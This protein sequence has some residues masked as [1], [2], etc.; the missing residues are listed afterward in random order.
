VL[1]DASGRLNLND[2]KLIIEAAIQGL[3]IAFVPALCADDALTDGRLIEL[4]NDWSTPF[5]GLCLYYASNR[6]IP[7]ALKAFIDIVRA[8]DR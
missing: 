3:G 5:P 7:S 1:I 2:N 6:H 4:L 8:C